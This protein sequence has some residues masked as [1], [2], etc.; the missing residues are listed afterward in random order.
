MKCFQCFAPLDNDCVHYSNSDWLIEP[1]DCVV[2]GLSASNICFAQQREIGE[3]GNEKV[4]KRRQLFTCITLFPNI[5]LQ[6]LT[7]HR[8]DTIFFLSRSW[9]SGAK[10]FNSR[11][12][13]ANISQTEEGGMTFSH[14]PQHSLRKQPTL[15]TLKQI[16]NQ[17]ETL[18][19]RLQH[20]TSA[21]GP[22]TSFRRDTS[23]AKCR[24]F[25][26]GIHNKR[27]ND[28]L[29]IPCSCRSYLK[30]SSSDS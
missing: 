30:L 21:L 16:F 25:S 1:Q 4:K 24:P 7:E 3:T 26:Q 6:S 27:Q 5:S 18:P 29:K 17:L 2:I 15:Q 28:S 22:Q 19:T 8:Q 20:G 23:D 14:H 13:L 12:V 11:K 9:I 10:K